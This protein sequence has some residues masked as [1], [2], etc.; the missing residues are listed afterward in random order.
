M[1]DTMLKA[2]GSF[3]LRNGEE[4]EEEPSRREA[5]KRKLASTELK[6]QRGRPKKTTATAGEDEIAQLEREIREDE[7]LLKKLRTGMS[8]AYLCKFW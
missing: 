3:R 2:T 4:D 1:N 8:H 7:Q 5:Q 6:R